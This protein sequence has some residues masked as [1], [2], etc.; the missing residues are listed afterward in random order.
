LALVSERKPGDKHKIENCLKCLLSPEYSLSV[1]VDDRGISKNKALCIAV[2]SVFEER[3]KLLLTN[4]ANVKVFEESSKI[5]SSASLPI[6]KE[7][8]DYCLMSKDEPITREDYSLKLQ[9]R[10]LLWNLALRK[11]QSQHLSDLLRPIR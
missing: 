7:I 10:S 1:G 11:A 4:G 8:L 6:L 5:L 2:E 9:Y 3:A